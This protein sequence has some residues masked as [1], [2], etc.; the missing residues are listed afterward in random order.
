MA[1]ETLFILLLHRGEEYHIKRK[2][3]IGGV[4]GYRL[5]GYGAQAKKKTADKIQESGAH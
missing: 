2:H 1:K 3:K 4:W 5:R